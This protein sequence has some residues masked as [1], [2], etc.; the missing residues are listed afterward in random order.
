L[1]AATIGRK[2]KADSKTGSVRY[3]SD[4][5]KY[6]YMINRH[7]NV[8]IHCNLFDASFTE[9]FVDDASGGFDILFDQKLY[10]P[11]KSVLELEK[12]LQAEAEA[13]AKQ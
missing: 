9:Y 3:P 13:A 12:Q 2:I 1:S 7:G 6:K 11:P 4:P 5:F 8:D 10:E